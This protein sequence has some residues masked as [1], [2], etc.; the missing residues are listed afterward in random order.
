MTDLSHTIARLQSRSTDP[1]ILAL[2][3]L[4][5][6]MARQPSQIDLTEA[7]AALTLADKHEN[8]NRVSTVTASI[9]EEF[10]ARDSVGVAKYAKSLDREDL[11]LD[12]WLQHMIEE[13][14]D[15]TGYARRAQFLIR[16]LVESGQMP[17]I[18]MSSLANDL[19]A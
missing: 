14:M 10:R 8:G 5:A 16:S 7:Q 13:L 4:V 19:A 17:P 11:T 2:A 12:Q 6:Q 9:V 3:S 18:L 1:A 15:A